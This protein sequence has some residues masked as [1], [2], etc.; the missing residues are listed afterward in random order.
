MRD[1]QDSN[2]RSQALIGE[3]QGSAMGSNVK[4]NSVLTNYQQ[5]QMQYLEQQSHQANQ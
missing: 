3:K 2:Q 5:R 4:D 1:S